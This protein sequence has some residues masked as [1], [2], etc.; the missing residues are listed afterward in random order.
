MP[1]ESINVWWLILEYLYGLPPAS[2]STAAEILT[3]LSTH[4]RNRNVISHVQTNNVEENDKNQPETLNENDQEIINHNEINK[5]QKVSDRN[6]LAG[7]KKQY[8]DDKAD[9]VSQ[10]EKEDDDGSIPSDSEEEN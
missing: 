7:E 6:I 1:L 9:D 3:D 10:V 8:D 2:R 4:K 5:N